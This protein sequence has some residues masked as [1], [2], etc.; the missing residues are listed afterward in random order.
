MK[1]QPTIKKLR[2]VL[3]VL[4]AF[5]VYLSAQLLTR[6]HGRI[7]LALAVVGLGLAAMYVYFGA[8]LP[9]LLDKNVRRITSVMLFSVVWLIFMFLA[10]PLAGPRS[11]MGYIAL[12]MAVL[13]WYLLRS[14]KHPVT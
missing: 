13:T 14:V 9:K 7:T 5:A 6:T 4:A 10:N 12:L 2:L 8:A 1:L 11:F 3:F